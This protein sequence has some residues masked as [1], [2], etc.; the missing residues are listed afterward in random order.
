MILAAQAG[1][2]NDAQTQKEDLLQLVAAY[3]N[4]ER[5]HFNLGGFYF[6]QQDFGQA[7]EHYKRATEINPNYSTA[8]N[9]LGYSYRQNGDFADAEKAFQAYIALIPADPN[10]YD[11]YAELLLRMGRYDDSIVQ[12]RKALEID[13]N[14]I[15]A[16]QGIAMDLLYAGKSGDAAAELQ[17]MTRKARTDGERRT[18]LFARTVLHVDGG[19]MAKALADL[20][21]Q[22]A[23]G[24]KTNDVG[25]M[26]FDLATRGQ[27]LLEMGKPDQARAEFERGLAL[28]EGS[29]LS[30]EIKANARLVSHYNLTR[31]ALAKNDFAAAEREAAEYRKGVES[32]KNPAQA[33]NAH[34]LD[35]IVALAEKKYDEA[36]AQ[37]QQANPQNPYNLYRLC[38]A[39]RGKGDAAKA[40]EYCD[41]AART[42]TLPQMNLAFVRSRA[43]TGGGQKG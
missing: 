1:V 9:L 41:R 31:V 16:H 37:L 12:Y 3:P 40:G 27:I 22:Y 24:Q 30:P 4:D 13:P 32:S 10:P 25:A 34:E 5:A 28:I 29:S 42:N 38:Q 39:Y 14:F 15:N 7:I 35:G 18:A 6:G 20:D 17:T 43:K 8:F 2:N 33:R 36:I 23:L 21:E 19:D 26:A 11:S